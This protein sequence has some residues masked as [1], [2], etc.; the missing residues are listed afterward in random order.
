MQIHELI[1]LNKTLTFNLA[2]VFYE[3][4]TTESWIKPV[5]ESITLLKKLHFYV[6]LHIRFK[7]NVLNCC[8]ESPSLRQLYLSF[9]PPTLTGSVTKYFSN[10][11]LHNWILLNLKHLTFIN[12]NSFI[13]A[14]FIF[15]L[16]IKALQNLMINH[17][18]LKNQFNKWLIYNK[19]EQQLQIHNETLKNHII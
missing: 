19:N 3:N 4:K 13:T 12:N 11:I 6:N 9:S 7:F 18:Y 10:N 16:N 2:E 14:L 5:I 17:W 8:F 1:M 15:L